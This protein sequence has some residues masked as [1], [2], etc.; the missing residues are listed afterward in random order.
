MRACVISEFNYKRDARGVCVLVEG[1]KPLEA[2]QTCKRD[3]QFWYDRTN[4]RKIPHSKCEGGLALDRGYQHACPGRQGR[5]WLFWLTMTVAP[6]L[7]AALAAVWWTR[8]RSG[9]GGRIRLPEPGEGNS[10][11]VDLLLSVP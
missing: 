4:L 8:R 6:F 3:Q 5:G 9:K 2:D 10:G 1:A 11:V 7:F